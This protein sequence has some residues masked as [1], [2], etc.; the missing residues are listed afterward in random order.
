MTSTVEKRSISSEKT[1]LLLLLRK[2]E[3][4]IRNRFI[5]YIDEVE[6]YVT[7]R[8]LTNLIENGN[9]REALTTIE[10]L[11]FKFASVIPEVVNEVGAASAAVLADDLAGITVGITFN[12]SSPRAAELTRSMTTTLTREISDSQHQLILELTE[13]GLLDGKN[14][15]DVARDIRQSIGLTVRQEQAVRNYRQLLED[16]NSQA[17]ERELRDRRHDR[18]VRRAIR[19]EQTLTQEQIDTMVNR[20]RKNYVKKRS[21]DIARTQATRSLAMADREAM[22]QALEQG[23]LPV[24]VVQRTWQY[25][26]DSRTRDAHRSMQNAR[27][28]LNEPFIDG[29]GNRLMYPGDPSA[30]AETTI[31]CRCVV[32]NRIIRTRLNAV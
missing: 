10:R 7:I 18:T 24:S 9:I 20:Y 4:K 27:A 15:R 32:T 29:N 30:P 13:R 31:N 6:D 1:R 25:T 5:E 14:A 23:G 12:P 11:T 26:R 17:L 28:G 8:Y 16:A 19:G 3:R 2:Q 22:Q 21:E